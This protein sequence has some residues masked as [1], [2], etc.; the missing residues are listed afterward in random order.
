MVLFAG[1]A[2][3][4]CTGLPVV[5]SDNHPVWARRAP[6]WACCGWMH[7][8]LD[9]PHVRSASVWGCG[10]FE[11][12]WPNRM[13]GNHRVN[14]FGWRERYPERGRIARTDWT[15][16]FEAFADSLSGRDV[17]VTVDMDCL[18]IDDAVT[19]WENG[20]FAA[21]DVAHAIRVLHERANVIGGDICGAYSSPVYARRAQ[22]FAAEWDHPKQPHVDLARARA[23]N[24]RSVETIWPALNVAG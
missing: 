10:N 20:L 7:R 6:H 13:F 14:A 2:R 11:L 21:E 5:A 24:T 15:A 8:A 16:Q 1:S 17:Y 12:N 18:S 4:G 23:I 19:N 22:R 9:L 3:N